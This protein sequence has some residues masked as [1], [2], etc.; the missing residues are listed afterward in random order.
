MDMS[1]CL[2]YLLVSFKKLVLTHSLDKNAS[3]SCKNLVFFRADSD[4]ISAL[5]TV[6][7]LQC[8]KLINELLF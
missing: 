3:M 5:E 7:H 2:F 8:N 6:V 1:K 4:A